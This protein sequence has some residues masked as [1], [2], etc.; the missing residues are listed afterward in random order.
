MS[1]QDLR[2]I[3][4][5][6][7]SRKALLQG[8]G[9]TT[10]EIEKYSSHW[11]ISP[12]IWDLSRIKTNHEKNTS[13][14]PKGWSM[15]SNS[16]G[17]DLPMPPFVV[18]WACLMLMDGPRVVQIFTAFSALKNGVLPQSRPFCAKV[19][20]KSVR[21]TFFRKSVSPVNSKPDDSMFKHHQCQCLRSNNLIEFDI[22]WRLTIERVSFPTTFSDGTL[23]LTPKFDHAFTTSFLEISLYPECNSTWN[24]AQV[25]FFH[26]AA[27][28]LVPGA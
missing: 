15:K 25:T 13:L 14:F 3:C 19:P 12:R 5:C 26:Y 18:F 8:S 17:V 21:P 20:G 23:Q 1:R 6:T 28:Q 7:Q 22:K 11:I 9:I 27:M 4:C 16:P 10:W 2:P 24:T